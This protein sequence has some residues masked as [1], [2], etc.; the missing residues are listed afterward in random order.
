MLLL[1]LLSIAEKTVLGLNA[2]SFNQMDPLA[3]D[4]HIDRYIG[5]HIEAPIN[6]PSSVYIDD[7]EIINATTQ[8]VSIHLTDKN[9]VFSEFLVTNRAVVTPLPEPVFI[10]HNPRR[11]PSAQS[12]SLH[13]T[14]YVANR[15]INLDEPYWAYENE[16]VG[17][18]PDDFNDALS[19]HERF[20]N[21]VFTLSDIIPKSVSHYGGQNV[22]IKIDPVRVGPCLCRFDAIIVRGA[23]NSS[24]WLTCRAPAHQSGR[25]AVFYSR[26]QKRWYG[27]IELVYELPSGFET[28]LVVLPTVLVSGLLCGAAVWGVVKLARSVRV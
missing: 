3:A 8:S 9:R 21:P 5:T 6:T 27:P 25:V 7:N 24:G 23:V 4:E 18:E 1:A 14:H 28:V 19:A 2:S 13:R 22:A 11:A 17:T 20:S 12:E 10:P 26:N 15:S 16:R